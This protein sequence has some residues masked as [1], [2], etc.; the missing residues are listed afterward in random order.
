MEG[1]SKYTPLPGDAQQEEQDN[2]EIVQTSV[3]QE[4]T[5]RFWQLE[6]FPGEPRRGWDGM[7]YLALPAISI[8]REGQ[9]QGWPSSTCKE[10][11]PHMSHVLGTWTPPGPQPAQGPTLV[12][13]APGDLDFCPTPD[14][15]SYLG[16]VICL[17][18]PGF[19][20]HKTPESSLF[21]TRH[22]MEWVFHPY[23]RHPYPHP[24]GSSSE[25]PECVCG[26]REEEI[27]EKISRITRF[28][29]TSGVFKSPP[30]IQS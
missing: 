11:G 25:Q 10:R 17:G 28:P 30:I 27:S 15:R 24:P 21:V 20:Q 8:T 7:G 2:I 19:W 9:Q 1:G 18:F 23:P 29:Q 14:S 26:H 13:A 16:Q 4:N 12:V 3:F 5:C 6:H 22:L